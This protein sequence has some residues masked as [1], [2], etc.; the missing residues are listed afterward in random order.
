MYNAQTG[1]LQITAETMHDMVLEGGQLAIT[2]DGQSVLIA[3]YPGMVRQYSLSTGKLVHDYGKVF[4]A[5][6]SPMKTSCIWTIKC[7]PDNKSFFVSNEFGHLKQFSLEDFSLLKDYG[8]IHSDSLSQLLVTA[9]G[10]WLYTTSISGEMKKWD[11]AK[12][13]LK[14]DFGAIYPAGTNWIFAITSTADSK[15]VFI[16]SSYWTIGLMSQWSVDT[17]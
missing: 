10:K 2:K 13:S 11:V 16:S 14:K 9:D 8:K 6:I 17:D 1:D 7:T 15:N 12:Q 5:E 3:G 4:K